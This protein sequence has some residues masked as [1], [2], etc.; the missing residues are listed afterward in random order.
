MP[1]DEAVT[2]SEWSESEVVARARRGEPEALAALYHRY[3]KRVFGLAWRLTGSRA[4]AEDVVQDLFV[5]LPEALKRYEDRGRLDAWLRAVVVRLVLMHKRSERRRREVALTPGDVRSAPPDGG[6][7]NRA[8]LDGALRA[9][10]DTMRTVFVLKAL[11]GYTHAEIGALL[12]IRAGT[13]EVRYH[14]AVRRLRAVLKE[15]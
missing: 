8:D 12:G 14:R 10:P 1:G 13:S 7:L 3:G 11:E 2:A 9:L 6:I 15:P 5:G 4:D